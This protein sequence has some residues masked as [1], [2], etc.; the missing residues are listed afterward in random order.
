MSKSPIIE[1]MDGFL[2][3]LKESVQQRN[4][5]QSRIEQYTTAIKA[6][7]QTCEN[8]DVKAEYLTALDELS[9]KPGFVSAIRTLLRA[10][11]DGLTPGVIK[12]AIQQAKLMDLT[13][14]SNPAASIYTTLRRMV[15][16]GEVELC[17]NL[18]GEKAYRLKPKTAGDFKRELRQKF[19]YK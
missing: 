4:E 7:A 5:L 12:I 6:L 2:A 10:H 3:K 8:E 14:Y 16:S 17:T 19:G 11:T 1:T 13:N 15:D 9:G 18:S